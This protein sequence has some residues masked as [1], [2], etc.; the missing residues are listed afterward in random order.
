MQINSKF[1]FRLHANLHQIHRVTDINYE[2]SEPI[3]IQCREATSV[4]VVYDEIDDG[5]V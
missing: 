3:A 5:H 4:S 2:F 1:Y